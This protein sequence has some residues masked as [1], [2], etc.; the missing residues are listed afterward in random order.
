MILNVVFEQRKCYIIYLVKLLVG[1][2]ELLLVLLQ[3]LLE[4]LHPTVERVHLGF[5]G[6]EVLLLL[7]QL[8]GDEGQ[9][10]RGEVQL[11]LELPGLG[12]QLQHL[13]LRLLRPELGHLARLLA[14]IASAQKSTSNMSRR[15]LNSIEMD[16]ET[17]CL[18]LFL[19][20]K[21]LPGSPFEQ[22]K[23]VLQSVSSA[24]RY[25]IAEVLNSR[26]GIFNFS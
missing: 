11:C 4:A 12:H 20:Q 23:Q 21:T 13:L 6:H 14:D 7:L 10:L 17:K 19:A 2:E 8:E 22:A 16:R 26:H 25:S 3:V 5:R 1:N 18:N 24:R 9:L 15:L